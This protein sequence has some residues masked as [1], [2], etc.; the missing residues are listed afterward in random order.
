MHIIQDVTP[1]DLRNDP[2][3]DLRFAA[4]RLAITIEDCR[5][6]GRHVPLPIMQGRA[7]LLHALETYDSAVRG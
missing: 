6:E 7:E 2:S 5:S 4:M 1:P 3:S